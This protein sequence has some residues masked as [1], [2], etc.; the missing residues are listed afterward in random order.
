M[1]LSEVLTEISARL[2]HS[3]TDTQVIKWVNSVMRRYYKYAPKITS[4]TTQLTSGISR[5]VTSATD[6]FAYENLLYVQHYNTTSTI[7]STDLADYTMYKRSGLYEAKS[8]TY[9]FDSSGALGIAP[10]P[11]TS[12]YRIIVTYAKLPTMLTTDLTTSVPEMSTNYHELL[13]YGA[14]NIIAKSGLYHD[15]D[16]ANNAQADFD[17][18]LSMAKFETARYKKRSHNKNNISYRDGWDDDVQ[19]TASSS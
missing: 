4:V 15:I 13:V 10:P 14:M 11:T 9:T 3:F 17:E 12:G 5:Y 19:I 18:L 16:V 6:G 8:D 1:L 7:A 2:P